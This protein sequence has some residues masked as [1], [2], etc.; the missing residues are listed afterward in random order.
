MGVNEASCVNCIECS[1]VKLAEPV[2]L[3]YEYLDITSLQCAIYASVSE[4]EMF[5]IC[6]AVVLFLHNLHCDMSDQFCS[7]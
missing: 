6:I 7:I 4:V 1:E 3:P 2:H 5:F